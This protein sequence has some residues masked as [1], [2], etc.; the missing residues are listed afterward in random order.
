MRHAIFMCF[1]DKFCNYARACL[2]SIERNYPDHPKILV[3]YRGAERHMLAFLQ[4]TNNLVLLDPLQEVSQIGFNLGPVNS[5]TVYIRYN[6]WTSH[7][8]EYDNILHLDAD[9]LV[10]K[11]LDEL[12]EMEDFFITANHEPFDFVR[13]FPEDATE[14]KELHDLL[15]IDGLR[16]PGGMDDMGNAGVFLLPKKYRTPVCLD[17]MI[18]L[19]KRYNKWLNYADQSALSLWCMTQEIPFQKR[20]EYNFQMPF[21]IMHDVPVS[22]SDACV[23]HYSSTYK[24]DTEEFRTWWR[25]GKHAVCVE[26]L[27]DMY[28]GMRI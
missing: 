13:V 19:T 17:K 18:Y 12:L 10:M 22:L 26:Q 25:L 6:L 2:N 7:F 1:D 23:L 5:P 8:E 24:P 3:D 28:L 27:Y 20:W 14:D 16:Y 11:P 4:A 15:R 9:T 21:L